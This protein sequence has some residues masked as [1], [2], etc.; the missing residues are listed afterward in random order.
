MS[1]DSKSP[2][3][4]RLV[5]LSAAILIT[6]G[7]LK[8]STLASRGSSLLMASNF[9][10]LPF[11]YKT[12]FLVI[13]LAEIW[14]GFGSLLY[15][16]SRHLLTAMAAFCLGLVAYRIALLIFQPGAPCSCLGALPQWIAALNGY[17]GLLGWVVAI[18][19]ISAV[20]TAYLLSTHGS[21][22]K[23]PQRSS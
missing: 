13:G 12:V 18:V 1:T 7:G 6:T 11:K 3:F 2:L 4:V 10:L 16:R 19:L 9:P 15:P 8:L 14:L 20:W 22:V 5:V 21:A 23:S 17:E